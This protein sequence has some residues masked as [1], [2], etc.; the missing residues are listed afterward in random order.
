MVNVGF[1]F[2]Q[3]SPLHPDQLGRL[4][5]NFDVVLDLDADF[6]IP[7]R[8]RSDKEW[9][10]RFFD[11][12]V[13]GDSSPARAIQIADRCHNGMMQTWNR[14]GGDPRRFIL[15]F[16]NELNLGVEHG[17][18]ANEA[19]DTEDAFER[20]LSFMLAVLRRLREHKP[21]YRL[22]APFDSPGHQD[23]DGR[24]EIRHYAERGLLNL[25]DVFGGHF[26]AR[27]P[28]FGG[29]DAGD[30]KFFSDRVLDVRRLLDGLGFANLPIY[31]GECNRVA[32]EF[33]DV[34]GEWE[35]YLERIKD[36]VAGVAW[37]IWSSGDPQ[38]GSMQ[39]GLLAGE[40]ARVDRLQGIID[41]LAN[42]G[43]APDEPINGHLVRFGF[44]DAYHADPQGL[45]PP[46]SDQ[47]FALDGDAASPLS[48]QFF[49]NA[50]LVWDGANV[51]RV[52]KG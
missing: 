12:D 27:G 17:G 14:H 11:S 23:V 25:I 15:Q 1:H 47:M 43:P 37:F 22:A 39:L 19:W 7:L 32:V 52:R 45:G 51:V 28:E 38:F 36:A 34:L 9:L 21:P 26:Y 33:G 16:C 13:M 6:Y 29:F 49:R 4:R 35:R 42:H 41:R 48:A 3:Q 10:I 31:V 18:R 40:P 2:H 20:R 50:V 30:A 24:Q 44:L 5:T 8:D 46:I